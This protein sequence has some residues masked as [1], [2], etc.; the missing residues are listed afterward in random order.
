MKMD[1]LLY[2]VCKTEYAQIKGLGQIEIPDI[3]DVTKR[4]EESIK[5][6]PG[7]SKLSSRSAAYK[8]MKQKP[9]LLICTFVLFISVSLIYQIPEVKAFTMNVIKTIVD[10][11]G[12][13]I[14]IKQT[15]GS[16][17]GN[18]QGENAEQSGIVSLSSLEEAQSRLPF[19][20]MS[21]RYLPPDY[22]L[23]G[24]MWTKYPYNLSVVNQMYKKS[25][26]QLIRI[27][28]TV[29]LKSFDMTTNVN[30]EVADVKVVNIGGSEVTF[31]LSKDKN[32]PLTV[33][34]A[35]WYVNSTKLE[36]IGTV[37]EDELISIING[38]R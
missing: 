10:F 1:E 12:N 17:V 37:S 7:T 35:M 31:I 15:G 30:A 29:N 38:L 3:D 32:N 5:R 14:K 26:K 9:A 19:H 23:E 33:S 21:P 18:S 11:G 36:V 20:L 28:Q 4:F 24:I 34:S 13:V 16:M 8:S 25:D 6:G 27:I 2:S 22:K